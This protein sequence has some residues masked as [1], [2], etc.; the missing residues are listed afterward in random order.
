[1]LWQWLLRLSGSELMFYVAL[2]V[3]IPIGILG[4]VL[5]R[6]YNQS[7]PLPSSR[8]STIELRAEKELSEILKSTTGTVPEKPN[9]S[10]PLLHSRESTIEVRAEKEL[11][12]VLKSTAVLRNAKPAE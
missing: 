9:R 2:P 12:E 7:Q 5:E 3:A 4:T 11:A 8:E 6:K 1:M 10:H